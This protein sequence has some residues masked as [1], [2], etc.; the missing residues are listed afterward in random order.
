MARAADFSEIF[1]NTMGSAECG[2]RIADDDRGFFDDLLL[3]PEFDELGGLDEGAA[4]FHLCRESTDQP[5]SF[6]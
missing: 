6:Q 3:D 1:K 2:S 4:E 5:E